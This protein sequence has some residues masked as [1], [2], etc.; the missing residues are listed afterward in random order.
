MTT[1]RCDQN[2]PMLLTITLT[3]APATDLGYLLHKSPGRMHTRPLAFGPSHVFYPEASEDRCTAALLPKPL[4]LTFI[5][6]RDPGEAV[7]RVRGV[8]RWLETRDRVAIE[9]KE[10]AK[11]QP[12]LQRDAQRRCGPPLP[13]AVARPTAA[14]F[15]GAAA[16]PAPGSAV[17]STDHGWCLRDR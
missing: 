8:G 3:Q 15:R 10:F 17:R 2:A 1:A 14:G 4:A 9:R 16:R 11:R 6:R 12:L 13:H 5:A 7:G